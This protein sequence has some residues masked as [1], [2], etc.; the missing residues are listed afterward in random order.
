MEPTTLFIWLLGIIAFV[1]HLRVSFLEGRL[2]AQ[3]EKIGWLLQNALE[4]IDI[5]KSQNEVMEELY[6]RAKS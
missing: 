4:T 2:D 5:L 3:T 1:L 6:R